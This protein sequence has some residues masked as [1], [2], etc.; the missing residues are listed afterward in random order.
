MGI[1]DVYVPDYARKL[2]HLRCRGCRPE[3][4]DSQTKEQS[5]HLNH[6]IRNHEHHPEHSRRHLPPA[7]TCDP[8]GKRLERAR[9]RRQMLAGAEH[10]HHERHR[11][12]QK[13]S[14]RT[15]AGRIPQYS[16]KCSDKRIASCFGCL[17]TSCNRRTSATESGRISRSSTRGP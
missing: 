6:Q 13:R 9:P 3:P 5:Q 16:I 10:G 12:H 14:R 8:P 11:R 2:I 4:Q 17:T 7:D 1:T 15:S